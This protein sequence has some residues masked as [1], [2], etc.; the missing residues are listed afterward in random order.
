MVTYHDCILRAKHSRDV[1][2][3]V[4]EYLADL[5]RCAAIRQIPE[6]CRVRRVESLTDLTQWKQ[7]LSTHISPEDVP[8]WN[9]PLNALHALMESAEQRVLWLASRAAVQRRS[10]EEKSA[11]ASK[12]DVKSLAQVIPGC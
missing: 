5:R 8:D 9:D 3:L 11:D 2:F 4:N 7:I 10:R 12:A 6:V 1:L